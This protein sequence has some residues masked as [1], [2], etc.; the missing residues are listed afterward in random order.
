MRATPSSAGKVTIGD[1]APDFT[2]PTQSGE[3]VRLHDLLGDRALVLF[4]YPKDNTS[5]CTAEVC[6]FRDSYEVFKEAGAGVVGVSSD[7]VDSHAAFV[8]KHNLPF[9]LLSDKGGTVRRLYGVPATLGLLPGRV[10][11]ILDKQ[12]VVRHMFSSQMAIG[13]HVSEALHVIEAL[14]VATDTQDASLPD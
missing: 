11:Y 8:G 9:T 3:Q 6:A 10:T 7:S 14:R 1:R 4:F 13:K 5:G 2:L 12:G